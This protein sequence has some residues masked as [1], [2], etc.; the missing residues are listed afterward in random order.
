MPR[1]RLNLQLVFDDMKKKKKKA[2]FV[3]CFFFF[4]FSNKVKYLFLDGSP[5]LNK[6]FFFFFFLIIYIYDRNPNQNSHTRIFWR[7]RESNPRPFREW[8]LN[9]KFV[10]Q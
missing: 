7:S 9:K 2:Q 10:S 3:Y 5:I 4:F 8:D 1:I 6:K